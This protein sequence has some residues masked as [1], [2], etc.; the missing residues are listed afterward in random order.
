M[1][2]DKDTE[3]FIDY[4]TFEKQYAQHTI[5]SYR[6]SMGWWLTFIKEKKIETWQ[7]VDH[8][9]IRHYTH[10]LHKKSLSNRSIAQS[11][12]VIRS[13][14]NYLY[15]NHK[16]TT[17][18]AKLIQSPKVNKTLPKVL[19]VDEAVGFLEALKGVD[20]LSCRDLAIM[21]LFYSSALRLSELQQL[22]IE[23]MYLNEAQVRVM[24]KGSKER[25]APLGK[26]CQKVM[27]QWLSI[28]Y[29]Y[30]TIHETALFISQRAQRLTTRSIQ[31]R[32][33]IWGKRLGLPSQLHP[34]KW[35][36]SCATHF[37]ESAHDLRAVQELLGHANLSTTQVY[38]HLDFQ[39]LANTYDA[40]HPRA[41]KEKRK[42]K[43]QQRLV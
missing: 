2:L 11:L 23:D 38:T 19:S 9:I 15:K 25:Y 40:A 21:E 41:K 31:K 36:H 13:L 8:H 22:N 30:D 1:S 5:V 27:E 7:R 18:P 12:S 29:Q 37:L 10:F 17:N 24:G 6:K 34:H 32:L 3:Q 4:L 39:Y 33:E 16:I 28:R 14:L 26:S 35:R 43:G 20:F 42:M